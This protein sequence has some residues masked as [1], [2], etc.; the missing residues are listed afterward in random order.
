MIVTSITVQSNIS[1]LIANCKWKWRNK[2][3]DWLLWDISLRL[4]AV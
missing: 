4:F 3:T 1:S 2:Q